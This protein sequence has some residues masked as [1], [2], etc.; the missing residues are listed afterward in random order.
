MAGPNLSSPSDLD[1]FLQTVLQRQQVGANWPADYLFHPVNN[2]NLTISIPGD[3]GQA[4]NYS[5]WMTR[6]EPGGEF[7]NFILVNTQ[8]QFDALYRSRP[9][10]DQANTVAWGDQKAWV[11]PDTGEVRAADVTEVFYIPGSGKIVPRDERLEFFWSET[12]AAVD[13]FE[14][15]RLLSRH[16]G[17]IKDGDLPPGTPLVEEGKGTLIRPVRALVNANLVRDGVVSESDLAT[18]LTSQGF[19][20]DTPGTLVQ[21]DDSQ[22]KAAAEQVLIGAFGNAREALSREASA[23]TTI[24]AV[25]GASRASIYQ[26]ASAVVAGPSV[27]AAESASPP[28]L[29]AADFLAEV[30]KLGTVTADQV[31]AAKDDKTQMRAASRSIAD[32]NS[33]LSRDP[34]A[35]NA[36]T[37]QR[38]L[39]A[40]RASPGQ[41]DIIADFVRKK[42]DSP[43]LAINEHSGMVM[44][45]MMGMR[46]A[47]E[48][49]TNITPQFQSVSDPGGGAVQPKNLAELGILPTGT[50]LADDYNRAGEVLDY[51]RHSA[52]ESAPQENRLASGQIHEVIQAWRQAGHEDYA[53]VMEEMRST[54]E[55]G[56]DP[57]KAIAHAKID[58]GTAYGAHYDHTQSLDIQGDADNARTRALEHLNVDYDDVRTRIPEILRNHYSNMT[59]ETIVEQTVSNLEREG[60]TVTPEMRAQIEKS[61]AETLPQLR[62][63]QVSD[64]QAD[65]I[66]AAVKGAIDRIA[67]GFN[68][69]SPERVREIEQ[70]IN[71]RIS[72]AVVE[73]TASRFGNIDER[74]D[75]ARQNA[76]DRYDAR[77]RAFIDQVN[78]M[79]PEQKEQLCARAG[80]NPLVQAAC[81]P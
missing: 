8:A 22:K 24:A 1:A 21:S 74:I 77:T 71:S 16:E 58:L 46:P 40:M 78:A 60:H 45:R 33:L 2:G 69:L 25:D 32:I 67:D 19:V 61:V 44:G 23:S 81:K 12:G 15:E 7:N 3:G 6:D 68:T 27:S 80:D 38:I 52:D 42:M 4:V 70:T 29:S 37:Q 36:E 34:K 72:Q 49:I 31:G 47:L 48:S 26:P 13:V 73:E 75:A 54:L 79:P 30:R 55:G 64:E 62:A 39:E 17:R 66:M 14:A 28:A 65:G 10:A 50:D 35:E 9:D 11:H 76:Q 51:I 20:Y 18:D 53:R 43:A 63:G 41:S 57:V 56:G 5:V 59:E